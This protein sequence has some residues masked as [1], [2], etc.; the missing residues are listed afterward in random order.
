MLKL[1]PVRTQSEGIPH[2]SIVFPMVDTWRYLL[3][4]W[5][6]LKLCGI[7]KVLSHC[8]LSHCH[9]YA[10]N[11]RHN[12][13]HRPVV[14]DLLYESVTA[15]VWNSYKGCDSCRVGY[16]AELICISDCEGSVLKVDEQRIIP[17]GFRDV[18][19]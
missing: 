8:T 14:Q 17:G 19:D 13:T 2:L 18:N 16:D 4:V 15:L 12:H 7:R 11:M 5:H 6:P 1:G 9:T 3:H 10:V